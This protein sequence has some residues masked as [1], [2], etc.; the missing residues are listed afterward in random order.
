MLFLIGKFLIL[1][2]TTP[3][4]VRDIEFRAEE[5]SKASFIETEFSVWTYSP[6]PSDA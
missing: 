2:W 3:K 5:S 4:F 1:P 6:I